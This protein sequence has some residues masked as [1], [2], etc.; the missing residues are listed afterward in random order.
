VSRAT[1]CIG[2]P[3]S[4]NVLLT[5]SYRPYGTGAPFGTVPGNKLP[6]YHHSV[7]SGQQPPLPVH[8][9]ES[10]SLRSPGFED[11]DE[12]DD[13]DKDEVPPINRPLA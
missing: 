8:I 10:K 13:E 9:F 12:D 3:K 5:Q 6:G 2:C 11:E 4:K 1:R 7:P